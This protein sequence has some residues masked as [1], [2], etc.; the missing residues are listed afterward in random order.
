MAIEKTVQEIGNEF[1]LTHDQNY[2]LGEIT[3]HKTGKK[4]YHIAA[5]L[6]QHT[7]NLM[8]II[9][10]S[11]E[12]NASDYHILGG[13]FISVDDREKTVKAKG[14]CSLYGR[15]KTNVLQDALEQAFPG[16]RVGIFKTEDH[17]HHVGARY[18]KKLMPL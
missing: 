2:L 9:R 12:S 5:G 13:G 15:P 4:H 16:Y 11:A 8:H 18:G 3:D 1:C 17:N 7:S 14:F 6:G 10:S